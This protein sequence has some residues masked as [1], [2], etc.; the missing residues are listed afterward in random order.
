MKLQKSI[1]YDENYLSKIVDIQRFTDH[2]NP[3][4]TRLK[5]AHVDGYN[6]IVGID[7]WL[8]VLFWVRSWE[9]L[10]CWHLPC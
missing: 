4:V 10:L 8:P 9:T 3:E 5:V 6:V 7:E 1:K 2:I